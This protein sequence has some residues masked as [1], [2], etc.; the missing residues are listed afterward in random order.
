MRRR[1]RQGQVT[2]LH[3]KDGDQGVTGLRGLGV[4]C[5]T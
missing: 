2:T 3:R 1:S 5:L 4:R